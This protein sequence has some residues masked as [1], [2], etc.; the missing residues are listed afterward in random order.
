[1]FDNVISERHLLKVKHKVK[2]S[3]YCYTNLSKKMFLNIRL[4]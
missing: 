3:K 2:F 1:M 4:K